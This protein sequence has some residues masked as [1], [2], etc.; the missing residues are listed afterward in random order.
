MGIGGGVREKYLEGVVRLMRVEWEESSLQKEKE[1]T[2][3]EEENLRLRE[4]LGLSR[5]V[6]KPTEKGKER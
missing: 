5:D 4:M 3:L 2:R 6:G 1:I